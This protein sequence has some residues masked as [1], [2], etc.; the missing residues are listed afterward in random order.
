METDYNKIT[1]FAELTIKSQE[2]NDFL[3]EYDMM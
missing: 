3:E 2:N 1:E